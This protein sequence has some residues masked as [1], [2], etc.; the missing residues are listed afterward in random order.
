M[1]PEI[2]ILPPTFALTYSGDRLF[3]LA[4]HNRP[5]DRGFDRTPLQLPK[6]ARRRV[7][8]TGGCHGGHHAEA[9]AEFPAGAQVSRMSR[10]GRGCKASIRDRPTP[11]NITNIYIF[12]ADVLGNIS[13]AHGPYSVACYT[14]AAQPSAFYGYPSSEADPNS[15][16]HPRQRQLCLHYQLVKVSRMRDG[17][18]DVSATD[19]GHPRHGRAT[20][21]PPRTGR[22]SPRPGPA[23]ARRGRSPRRR[24]PSPPAG[25]RGPRGIGLRHF[26]HDLVVRRRDRAA[27]DPRL[28][29]S[30]VDHRQRQHEGVGAGALDRQIEAL[31]VAVAVRIPVDLVYAPAL[32][33]DRDAAAALAG[34]R[35]SPGTIACSRDRSPRRP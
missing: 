17:I 32:A 5:H 30:R 27:L 14:H 26:Q 28:E 23:A 34:A 8:R 31:R 3:A 12:V 21:S 16:K 10:I 7:Q 4:P 24:R 1:R 25:G 15:P 35:E 33:P 2:P 11:Y 9:P 20:S 6:T 22:S 18:R 29:Q 19:G 13:A